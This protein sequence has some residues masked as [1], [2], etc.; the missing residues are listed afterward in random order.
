MKNT[1]FKEFTLFF[2]ILILSGCS[3]LMMNV[4]DR[5]VSMAGINVQ[6]N[7]DWPFFYQPTQQT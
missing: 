2:L 1:Y 7:T 6:K 5:S 4:E 3:S